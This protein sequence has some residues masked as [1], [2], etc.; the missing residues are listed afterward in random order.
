MITSQPGEEDKRRPEVFS[1]SKIRCAYG[2]L[3]AEEI[4]NRIT[5]DHPKMKG[6]WHACLEAFL[7]MAKC[8]ETEHVCTYIRIYA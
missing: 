5:E 4:G 3:P 7:L 2:I 6:Y 1:G 8:Q